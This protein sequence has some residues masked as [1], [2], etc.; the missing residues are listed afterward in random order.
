MS[1]SAVLRS[2]AVFGASGLVGGC[3]VDR[4]L[5][6]HGYASVL[7]LNRRRLPRSHTRLRQQIV[8]FERP[9][10]LVE[11]LG[12]HDVFCCLGTTAAKAGSRAAFYRVDF[13][14]VYQVAQAARQAGADQ[15]V[16]VS[17]IGADPA[18]RVYYTRVKGDIEEA[19]ATLEFP[20]LQIFRPSLLAGRRGEFRL[21]ERAALLAMSAVA[22][23]LR[24]RW[25]KYRPIRAGAVAA[26]MVHVARLAPRGV[27]VI[28]SDRIAEVAADTL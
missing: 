13:T 26:A 15:F 11:A 20:A 25:V 18:S 12:V 6:D 19:L 3:L 7:T 24:G 5:A 9:K 16:L 28:E 4:L 17:S 14:T 27:N 21:G 2:A 10:V 23:F 1:T 8:N 22:P